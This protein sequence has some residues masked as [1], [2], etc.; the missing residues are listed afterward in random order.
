[1]AARGLRLERT[2][3]PLVIEWIEAN[4]CHGPGDVQGQTL[5]LD[6]E[7]VRLIFGCYAL[8]DRGRRLVR[9]AVF[10]RP[11]GRAKSELAA[12]LVCAEALGPTRFRGWDH[13]GRPLGGPVQAPYVPCV[14][15]EEGQA[16][17]VYSAAEFMLREGPISS[18]RGLDV[19]QTRTFLPDGGVIRPITARASSKEGG[20]ESFAV[21][22][23]THL[24]LTPELVRLHETIRRNLSKRRTAEP[25]SLEV[26]TMY[27]PG[28]ESVAELSH[29]YAESIGEKALAVGFL[30]DHREAPTDIDFADDEQLRA[31]LADVYGAAAEWVDLERLLAEARDPQTREADFRRYWLNQ[32]TARTDSWLAPQVWAE[33]GRHVSVEDGACVVLGFDGSYNGDSTGLVGCTIDEKPHL[34]VLGAWERP[35]GPRGRGWTVPR[36]HVKARVQE[37]METYDVAELACDPPGWHRE[38]D[39]WAD[40]YADT[41]TTEFATNRRAFMAAAC[42]RFYTAAM[43]G[44]LTHDGNAHLARH[45]ANARLKETPDGAYIVKDGRNSPRKIDLAVAAVIALDRAAWHATHRPVVASWRAI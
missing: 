31:A 23:E 40:R 38:I 35:E 20:R 26:S 1:M 44:T 28:E 21:F 3:G 30:F 34:F 27:A 16:G 41:V 45:L 32:A 33:R 14:A 4:L 13:D 25:W 11:K 8:D 29:R 37:A 7:Q 10:S 24:F 9:R 19:G 6:D 39:E 22:D 12:M 18:M 2:L 15:T 5:E 17:N 42:S 36:E 43:A